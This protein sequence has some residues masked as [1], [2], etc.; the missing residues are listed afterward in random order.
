MRSRLVLALVAAGSVLL[1]AAPAA[2]AAESVAAVAAVPA[3]APVALGSAHVLDQVDVLTDAEEQ[4]LEDRLQALP[5]DGVEL[6]V[7]YVD[8][9]TD[10]ADAADWA[11]TTAAANNLGPN[12]YLLAVATEGRAYYLSGD[13]S[14][15]VSD[16]Q[17]TAIEQD[18]IAPALRSGDW[19]GAATAAADG[20]ADAAGGSGFPIW[21]VLLVVVVVGIGILLAVII[22]RSR[23]KAPS[24][25]AA[26]APPARSTADLRRDA[27]SALVQADDAIKT[28]EQELGFAIAQFGDETAR[29]FSDALA[30]AK[31]DIEQAFTL[32]QQLDDETADTEQQMRAWCE[33][34]LQLCA[35]A[36]AVLDE[37]AAAFDRLRA[38]EQNAPEA[39]TRAQALRVEVAAGTDAASARL[40][41]LQ[42]SYAPEAL[43]PVA[44]NPAQ[45]TQRLGF[46]DQQLSGAQQAIG[47]GDGSQAAVHIRAAEEAIA[48]ARQLQVAVATLGD[49]LAKADSAAAALI[50]DIETDLATASSVPDPDGRLAPVLAGTRRQV[51]AASALLAGDARRPLAALEQL[52]AANTQIDALL[53]GI[54]DAQEK[55]R[56]AQQQLTQL[57]TQAQAQV[58]AAEDFI[59]ARR[60]AV[61]ATARTRLAEAGSSL[62]Q[63]RQL[64]ASDPAA[65][66]GAAQRAN[67][68]AAQALR[69]AQSDV[70]GFSGGGFGDTGGGGGLGQDVMGAVLGG[71]IVNA[72]SGGGSR[73]R[74]GGGFG[75]LGGGSRGGSRG[76][77]FSPGS[78]GGGGTRARRGGGRF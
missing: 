15:P 24:G 7:A 27:A 29:E 19:V 56:R 66:L 2:V 28:S 31:T 59:T 54:R 34:I 39:L 58:S 62:V 69:A 44:D 3:T 37:K 23:K 65:A 67:D 11:N 51:D 60:G 71:I 26:P 75:G 46:A 73:G 16:T 22:A 64:A 55:S 20:L 68:L 41:T 78:F 35:H 53:D 49:E 43:A 38:L 57:M 47:A 52:E 36:D 30:A 8:T 63:A 42:T 61:G 25:G 74:S 77:G 40:E 21:L 76:G 6:W 1:G 10:P 14:G 70:G 5:D 17:L 33:Q 45:A 50:A 18:R 9:F 72:L 12:Q 4:A 13:S 32:Q 48:Q